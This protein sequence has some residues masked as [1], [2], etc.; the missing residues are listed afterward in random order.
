VEGAALDETETHQGEHEEGTATEDDDDLDLPSKS[1]SQ[2]YN[3]KRVPIRRNSPENKG[4]DD[5]ETGAVSVPETTIQS[6]KK[7]R[8]F[9]IGGASAEVTADPLTAQRSTESEMDANGLP[10]SPSGMDTDVKAGTSKARKR[11]KI[12]GTASPS[13][14]TNRIKRNFSSEHSP[15]V[16]SPTQKKVDSER[17]EA[18]ASNLEDELHEE[19]PEERAARRRRELERKNEELA[20]KQAHKKRKRF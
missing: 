7:S 13:P 17:G 3:Q 18:I 5:N 8:G 11:F 10:S 1:R 20:K 19:T 6:R 4:K 12:G 16:E 14:T 9:R 2:T 15:V